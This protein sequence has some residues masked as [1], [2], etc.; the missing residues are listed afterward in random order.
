M[1]Y[2]VKKILILYIMYSETAFKAKYSISQIKKIYDE[3]IN[4]SDKHP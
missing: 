1:C 3:H 4:K 2:T